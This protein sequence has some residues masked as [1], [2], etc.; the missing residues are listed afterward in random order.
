MAAEYQFFD[1]A[2]VQRLQT[3]ARRRG[4]D[5]L[6][7]YLRALV[8]ADAAEHDEPPPFDED[9]VDIRAELKEGIRQALRGETIPLE[10]LWSDDD[11]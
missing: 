9:E 10:S 3:I 7:E 1:E 11:D 8:D 6:R 5:A 4:Y 2:E